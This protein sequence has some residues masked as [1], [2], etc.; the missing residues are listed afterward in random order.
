MLILIILW[1]FLVNFSHEITNKFITVIN[2]KSTTCYKPNSGGSE[3]ANILK[4]IN[5]KVS[6]LSIYQNNSYSLVHLFIRKNRIFNKGRYSRNR[7]TCKMAFYLALA[8]HSIA[9]T[10]L[11]MWYYNLLIKFT[12][13]WYVFIIW[14]SIGIFSG[15]I[16][17]RL[18]TINLFVNN[19]KNFSLWFFYIILYFTYLLIQKKFF[20][21]L[22]LYIYKY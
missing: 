14:I 1:F 11:F 12:Y 22:Y 18:Y 8:I 6:D 9:V 16:R 3:C 19:I 2:L 10:G 15:F 5:Y 17:F 20:N 7:Q 13:M 4:D 21:K